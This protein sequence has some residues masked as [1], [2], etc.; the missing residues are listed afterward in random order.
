V[1][2]YSAAY[3]LVN[4]DTNGSYDVFVKDLQ[5]GTITLISTSTNGTQGSYSVGSSISDDG[6][7]VAF[8]SNA[9]LVD[10]DINQSFD[11]FVKDVQTGIINRISTTGEYY[12]SSSPFISGNGRYVAFESLAN[13]LVSGDTNQTLDVFVKD[14]QTGTITLAST[15]ANGTQGN[16]DSH[17]SGISS[18]GRYVAFYSNAKNL[19]SD[20]SVSDYNMFVKDMQTGIIKRIGTGASGSVSFSSDGRYIALDTFE[21]G[22]FMPTHDVFVNDQGAIGTTV[23][24]SGA[25]AIT[26]TNSAPTNLTLSTSSL[27]ENVPVN[28]VVGN[29]SSTDPDTGNTFTY[30]LVSGT[31]STDNSSF[32]IINGNQLSINVSPDYETKSSYSVRVR[33]T[34]QGGLTYE[35]A[36]TIGVNNLNDAPILVNNAA[37]PVNQGTAVTITSALLQTTDQDNTAAQLTYTLTNLPS[38]GTLKLSGNALAVGGKFTQDDINNSRVTY[39]QNGSTATSDSFNFTIS[40][41]TTATTTRISV[42]TGGKE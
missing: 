33:T 12:Y 40:D 9:N 2:F 6:R 17:L 23:S 41:A 29:F 21:F 37:I 1:A 22:G 3:N 20:Y 13:D 28:T 26:Q 27:N 16:G 11:V 32:S 19:V 7:Y 25:I 15:A 42:S 10:G 36:L 38:T 24:G 34:D 8:L 30:S 4:S 35:K 18:D 31:G 5:T 39:L 14:M